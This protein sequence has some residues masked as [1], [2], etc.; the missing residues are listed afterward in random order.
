MLTLNCRYLHVYVLVGLFTLCV[1]WNQ[2]HDGIYY[3]YNLCYMLQRSKEECLIYFNSQLQ[4][5]AVFQLGRMPRF[6]AT[7]T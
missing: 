7:A 4:T 6:E 5:Q 1:E 2:L 3:N